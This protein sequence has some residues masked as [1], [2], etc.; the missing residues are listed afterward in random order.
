MPLTEKSIRGEKKW[1]VNFFD[2]KL[3]NMGNKLIEI[4]DTKIVE[5][6]KQI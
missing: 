3:R 6:I 1:Q 4:M 2:D 5:N